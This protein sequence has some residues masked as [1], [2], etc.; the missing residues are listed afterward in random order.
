ME[1][2][3][4]QILTPDQRLRVFVS[5]T[6]QELAEER[7]AVKNA[8]QKIQLTP[9]MFELGARPHAP[10]DL[11]RQYLAQSQIFVGIYWDSYGWVAPGEEISGLEDEYLRSG[12]MPKLIYIKKSN[13]SRDARLEELIHRI[14][15]DDK[16]SYKHFTSPEEL[17]QLIVNDLAVLLTERFNLSLQ[18]QSLTPEKK[19]FHSLPSIPDILIG[20]EKNIEEIIAMLKEPTTH[21]VTLTGPGGIGKTRLSIE[22]AKRL[23][24]T[25]RD[26]VAYVPLAPVRDASLVAEAICYTL[27]I[28]VSGGNIL[29]SLK[30]FLQDKNF[31][32][33]LDNFEQIIEAASI[34]DDILYAAPGLKILVTSRERL[35][36]SFEHVYNVPTLSDSFGS[37]N[38]NDENSFPPAI[39]LFIRRAKSV[40]PSF[41]VN[42]QNREIIFEI[43]HRLE[44]L[45]LAIE[46]AAG[47]INLF[48]P[49]MLLQ[50]LDH[51]LDVLKGNFRDIPD[52]Q[53]TIRNTIEW[54][55]DLLS[56]PEQELLLNLSL[57]N[58]GCLL[59]TVEAISSEMD[60]VYNTLDSLINKSLLMKQDEDFQ[61][62]FQMLETVREFAIEKLKS[63]NLLEPLKQKQA[64][65]YHT[66][67]QGIKLQKNKI[68]QIE[69]LKFLEKEHSNIRLALD[70][71]M[72]KRDICKVT[73]IAWNLWLFWWVNAHTKEGYTWLKKAWEIYH[74]D[75]TQLDEKTFSILASNVGFMSFLQR[76]FATFQESL[77]MHL[78]LIL[79]QDDDE[80]VAT[81]SLITG[82]VKT[83]MREYEVADVLLQRSLEHYKK[84][85]LTTGISLA[86]SA[87]GRN[88]IYYGNQIPRAKAYYQESMALAKKDHNEIAVIIC[89][90]GFALCE[91]MEKNVEAK[92]YL[93][94]SIRLS[95]GIHFYEAIAW[96]ME[97]W[98]LNS[99][100]ENN[101]IHAVTLMGAVDH[102][103]TTTH[104]PVWEDL[105][106]IIQDAKAR[107][108]NQMPHDI[109]TTAWN[110][111]AGLSLDKM[112]QYAM[113]EGDAHVP[114]V[115]PALMEDVK[116]A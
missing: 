11:Y 61:V 19:T 106:A 6:L 75:K 105:Q 27:G 25:F 81:A 72:Q 102:L 48:S 5:S 22:T 85:Q 8:I 46:L 3:T 67:L 80:L 7:I 55:F 114:D 65:Y 74:E 44:G 94:E 24:H 45:P 10:R 87:L 108:Q 70:Y 32:L 54:S 92:N 86:L 116:A 73:G 115:Q 36:L 83:I 78:D 4:A 41:V 100:N 104:L 59:T 63:Q 98:A 9:V 17:T 33:V 56:K 91:V 28:K 57:Y 31:L 69:I 23:Q 50:R 51:R 30:L 68:D 103:R 99:I 64:D 60:D 110:H 26:G 90:T 12:N 111:G 95:Q 37:K 109:F 43:C 96:S 47:Q 38:L 21:L 77:I 79:S 71:L 93:R 13:G 53:K 18:E 49:A 35:S 82:V 2:V 39:E 113:S 29:D 20:R 66:A 112:L 84:I 14:Q 107:I 101:F 16:V 89:L 97:I 15:S 58:A 34:I 88:A 40:K 1:T 76:D 42:D 62:R 52:R